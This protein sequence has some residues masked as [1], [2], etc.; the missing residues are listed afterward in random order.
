M[1]TKNSK[2]KEEPKQDY[3]GVHFRHCYQG[4]YEDSC[5][6]GEDN[7]PAKPKEEPKQEFTTVNGSSGCTITITDEIGKPLTYWGGLK[8]PKQ[9]TTMKERIPVVGKTYHYFDDGK[10]K[11]SRRGKVVITEVIPFENIDEETLIQ[12]K[13]AVEE[14]DWLY[15]PKTD[16]FVK[17]DTFFDIIFV[18]TKDDDW[19]SFGF[20][21]GRLDID[22]SLNDTL[23]EQWKKQNY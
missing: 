11:V 19:F 23:K 17:V 6:Y 21:A 14:C 7:C 20:L 18:R 9:Q 2:P 12:W 16:F 5:K 8:E 15:A 10:I 22:G 3:S 13:E 4:E 1:I